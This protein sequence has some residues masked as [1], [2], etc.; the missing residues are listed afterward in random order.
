LVLAV[1]LVASV[2]WVGA[3]CAYIALDVTASIT[4]SDATLRAMYLSMDR[5]AR[6]AILPLALASL[7]TGVLI[8]LGT[9]WGLLRHHWVV[10][11]LILTS[12][13]T[14]VLVRELGVI[15]SFARVAAD[16][17]SRTGDVRSLGTTLG[18]S[19][20]GLVVLLVIL[21][22]NVYKPA[23]VTRYGRRRLTAERE[24]A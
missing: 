5:I 9:R 17:G 19:I 21:V 22:L 3:A 18:H 10:V 11:S 6:W 2:G 23:G 20:G 8:A 13:A 4:R 15:A 1:H 12:V 7:A 14:I 24:G 16:P